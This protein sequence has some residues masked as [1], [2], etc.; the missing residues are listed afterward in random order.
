MALKFI[1]ILPKIHLKVS[2]LDFDFVPMFMSHW[3]EIKDSDPDI[4]EISLYHIPVPLL[5]LRKMVLQGRAYILT[6]RHLRYID[7][8]LGRAKNVSLSLQNV[9]VLVCVT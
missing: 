7:I 4:F 6:W 9:L 2:S 8:E 1:Y 5:R 3:K